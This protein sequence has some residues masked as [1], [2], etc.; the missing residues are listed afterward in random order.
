[1]RPLDLTQ[2]KAAGNSHSPGLPLD[3]IL[4]RLAECCISRTLCQILHKDAIF[5]EIEFRC[6][7]SAH[8]PDIAEGEHHIP[9]SINALAR[10]FECP[11]SRVQP[12]L[13]HSLES[14]GQWGKQ[15]PL[16]QPCDNTFS[17]G[18]NKTAKKAHQS[19][20]RKSKITVRVNSKRQSLAAGWI[21]LF[22]AIPT[23][24]SDRKVCL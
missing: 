5:R 9:F 19:T 17:I 24:S 4:P 1:M 7:R 10:P 13:A 18:F 14:P 21:R 3:I 6:Q 8:V 16:D 22:F 12:A 2:D 15:T 20:K 11:R 23:R